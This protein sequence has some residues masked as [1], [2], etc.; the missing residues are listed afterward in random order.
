[1]LND[2]RVLIRLRVFVLVYGVV[3]GMTW[4]TTA[5]FCGSSGGE[6]SLKLACVVCVQVPGDKSSSYTSR[7]GCGRPSPN[8][9]TCRTTSPVRRKGRIFDKLPIRQPP[10]C[11]ECG[12]WRVKA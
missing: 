8:P 2:P 5:G 12:R 6:T 7:E 1:V 10:K 3:L 9:T 11:K 4:L